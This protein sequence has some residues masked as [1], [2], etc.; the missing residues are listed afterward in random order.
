M[1]GNKGS[2]ENPRDDGELMMLNSDG[3]EKE[4]KD[5]KITHLVNPKM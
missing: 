5:K 4:N 1:K 2:D 3:G